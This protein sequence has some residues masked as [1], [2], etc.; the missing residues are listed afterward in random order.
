MADG[1]GCFPN[2]NQKCKYT[3]NSWNGYKYDEP[4]KVGPMASNRAIPGSV[5]SCDG[6]TLA[7][8]QPSLTVNGIVK[9]S[10]FNLRTRNQASVTYPEKTL[11]YKDCSLKAGTTECW[12]KFKNP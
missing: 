7:K 5:P 8:H 3:Q 4:I 10:M 2:F 1:L 6:Y 11:G 12:C 9:F